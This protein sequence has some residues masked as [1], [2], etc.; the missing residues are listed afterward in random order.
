MTFPQPSI[1]FGPTEKKR[2][3]ELGNVDLGELRS[4]WMFVDTLKP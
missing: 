2:C 4:V 1:I 3:T